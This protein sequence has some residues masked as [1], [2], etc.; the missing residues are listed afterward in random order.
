MTDRIFVIL[1]EFGN[2]R[3]PR[4][5]DQDT[6]PTTPGPQRF[7]GPVHNQI[8]EPNRAVDNQTVWQADYNRAHYQNLYFGA[9]TNV[10]S[11]RRTTRRSPPAGTAWTEPSPTG[12]R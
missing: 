11:A 3:D 2:E 6:D 7:D 5:P 8:P 1:A 9:G 10:E 12:S 4:F